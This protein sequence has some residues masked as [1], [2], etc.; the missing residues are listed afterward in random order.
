MSYIVQQGNPVL[1]EIAQEIALTDISS[2]KTKKVVEDMKHALSEQHDG[3]AIAAPQ[4]GA[5][6]RIFV[7]AKKVL[8][9]HKDVPEDEMVCINPKIVK[10]SKKTEWKK[11]EGCLSC[12]WLYGEV[13]RHTNVT[14]EYYDEHGKKHIRGAGGLLA[15]IFQ[16][17]IDHL[18]GILFIDRARNLEDLPPEEIASNE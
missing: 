13:K 5:S 14:I 4:I 10:F 12:R 6:L 9:R 16:H 11:G 15:H 3:V 18:D 1:R 2:P 7:V 17:E 8:T